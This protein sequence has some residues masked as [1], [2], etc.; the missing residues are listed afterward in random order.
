M[1]ALRC[2]TSPETAVPAATMSTSRARS[3]ARKSVETRVTST[4]YRGDA[5][6][7]ALW[8]SQL[9]LMLSGGRKQRLDDPQNVLNR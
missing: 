1:L 6:R 8:Q 2:G 9:R 7:H 3:S 5:N 4:R